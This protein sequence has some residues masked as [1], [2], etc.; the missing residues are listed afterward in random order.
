MASLTVVVRVRDSVLT[1]STP[2]AD[3]VP[4]PPSRSYVSCRLFWLGTRSATT[5]GESSLRDARD[6]LV[7]S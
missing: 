4:V 1:G 2:I 3:S 6:L 5:L 7:N